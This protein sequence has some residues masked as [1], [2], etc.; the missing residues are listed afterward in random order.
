M[1]TANSRADNCRHPLCHCRNFRYRGCGI[2]RGYAVSEQERVMK[3]YRL[4]R[5]IVSVIAAFVCIVTLQPT[6][7]AIASESNTSAA[8][9]WGLVGVWRTN[10]SRPVSRKH[11]EY[12]FIVKKGFLYHDRNFGDTTD[13]RKIDLAVVNSDGTLELLTTFEFT[14]PPQTR[15]W[16]YFKDS[17]GRKRVIWNR[18]VDTNGYSIKDSRFT[19]SGK[20]APWQYKCR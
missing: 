1:I 7:S 11:P 16:K 12:K 15:L 9:R 6:N 2:G 13:S 5:S 10:C 19:H 8:Q 4:R 17:K 14:K 20:F 18:N 3:S